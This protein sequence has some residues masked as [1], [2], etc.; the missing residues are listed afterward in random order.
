MLHSIKRLTYRVGDLEKAR[1]WYR[2]ILGTAPIHDSPMAVIFSVGESALV[3]VP[4]ADE[5]VVAYWDVDDIDEAYR[6]L[7]EAG[8][9]SRCEIVRDLSGARLARVEDPFGNIIGIRSTVETNKTLDETPSDTAASVAL[10]RALATCEESEEIRGAD[11]LA[12]LFL[13]ADRKAAI[14]QPAARAYILSFMAASG[15]YQYLIARTAYIDGVVQQALADNLPQIV[16]LGAGY[17]SRPYRFR[18]LIRDTRLF[19]LDSA[20]TQQRKR[21]CLAQGDVPI[22]AQLTFVPVEFTKDGL[23]DAFDAAGFDERKKT[24]FVWEGV[25][26]YLPVEAIDSTLGFV[27]HHTPPGSVVCFD[28]VATAPDMDE[29]YGVKASMEAMRS[30]HANEPILCRFE[31]GSIESFLA[32]RG[33]SLADHLTPEDMEQRFLTLRDGSL[34]G[35]VLASFRLA[36]ASV[37]PPPRGV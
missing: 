20:L 13:P 32:D 10:L 12:S 33:F 26:C 37:L 3:L 2:Q 19:E 24:L 17:D 9:A 7:L 27:R 11:T 25:T 6:R 8:A 36:Q 21:A 28:Y 23:R 22:P 30:A 15:M 34:T 18:D 29:R 4:S 35:H 16:F 1:D 31:E 14:T 5:R